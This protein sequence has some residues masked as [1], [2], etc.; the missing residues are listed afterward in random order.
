MR[1]IFKNRRDL[2]LS[3][4]SKIKNIDCEKPN[5]AFY[6]FPNFRNYLNLK[7]LNNNIIKTASELSMYILKTT[8]VVTVSGDS[9]GAPGYIRFSY[10]TSTKTIIKAISLVNETLKK[11]DF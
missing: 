6:V 8:G 9:F 10:A 4:L 7:D 5:G 1:T 2:I 11:L 3:E